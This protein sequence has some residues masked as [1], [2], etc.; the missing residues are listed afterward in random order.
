MGQLSGGNPTGVYFQRVKG[1]SKRG[2]SNSWSNAEEAKKIV[3]IFHS[4]LDNGVPAAEIGIITPYTDQVNLIKNKIK[5][6]SVGIG[7]VDSFQGQERNVIIVSTVRSFKG[8]GIGFVGD[9]KRLNV[10]LSRAKTALVIVGNDGVLK[11]N[12]LFNK[13]FDQGGIHFIK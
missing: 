10:T 6:S 8:K 5:I 12:E 13:F 3:K 2:Q 4:L 7:S 9:A 1:Y 11:K